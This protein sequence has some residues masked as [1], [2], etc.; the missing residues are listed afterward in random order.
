MHFAARRYGEAIAAVRETIRI[1]PE[2][3]DTRSRVGMALLAQNKNRE[4]LVEFEADSHKWSKLAGVA[5]AQHRLG[6]A[7]AA[8]AA[9]DELVN[10]TETVSLYQQGQILAQWGKPE[11]AVQALTKARELRDGGMTA[12]GYDPMLDPLRKLPD[13][14][15]LLK[16][17]G[18]E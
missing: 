15:R 16:A 3:T 13:F 8:K 7:A 12:V 17:M 1:S 11:E 6:N 18:F 10:D 5:I 4:A 14:I 2:L 9:Y